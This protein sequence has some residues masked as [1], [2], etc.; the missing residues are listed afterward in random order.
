VISDKLSQAHPLV[1]KI[2]KRSST[3]LGSG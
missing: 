2:P 3:L 1:A